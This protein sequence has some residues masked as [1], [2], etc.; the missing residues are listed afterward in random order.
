[1]I[2]DSPEGCARAMKVCV[3]YFMLSPGISAFY[4]V[5]RL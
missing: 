4:N 5:K 3:S 2:V 1:M